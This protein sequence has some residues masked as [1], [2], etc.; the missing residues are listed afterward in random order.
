MVNLHLENNSCDDDGVDR[1]HGFGGGG[2]GRGGIREKG[3]GDEVTGRGSAAGMG[4][5]WWLRAV[6]E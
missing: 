2:V 5:W 6:I 4:R 3:F 1:E